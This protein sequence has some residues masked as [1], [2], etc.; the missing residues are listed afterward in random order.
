MKLATTFFLAFVATLVSTSAGFTTIEMT[1]NRGRLVKPDDDLMFTV[2]KLSLLRNQDNELSSHS[3][4]FD[5]EVEGTDT[6]VR[7]SVPQLVKQF[8]VNRD[9][10]FGRVPGDCRFNN[11]NGGEL[12]KGRGGRQGGAGYRNGSNYHGQNHR[13]NHEYRGPSKNQQQ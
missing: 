11:A 8:E 10:N 5:M 2:G 13:S 1:N 6:E 4:I 12:Y 7:A 9:R 3:D